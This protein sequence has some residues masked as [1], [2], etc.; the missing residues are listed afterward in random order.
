MKILL[1]LSLALLMSVSFAHV[2]F[3][4]DMD[5][6]ESEEFFEDG[7]ET[8]GCKRVKCLVVC[9]NASVGGTLSVS[10]NETVGG[11]LAVSG[12]VTGASFALSPAAA[13]GTPAVPGVGGMLAWGEVANN[14][15]QSITA[16]PTVVQMQIPG[17]SNNGVTPIALTGATDGLTLAL[18]GVYMFQYEATTTNA[19]LFTMALYNSTA[20]ASVPNSLFG[21]GTTTTNHVNGFVIAVIAAP[22]TTIQLRVESG[23]NPTTIPAESA[24]VGLGAKLTAIRLA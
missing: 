4:Q 22:A 5:L 21:N 1:K 23:T 6:E 7:T 19:N 13:A 18:P 17:A 12:A 24:T 14:A 16:F 10:G 15:G 3:A 11:N 20:A 9:G 8:R 2:S